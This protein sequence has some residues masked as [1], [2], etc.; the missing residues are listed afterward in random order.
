MQLDTYSEAYRHQCE[1]RYWLKV[2]GGNPDR[3]NE[4]IKRIAGRRGKVAAEK[5]LNGMREQ[6]KLDRSAYTV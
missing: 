3:V 2:T 6:Y 4:L 5:L 1:C